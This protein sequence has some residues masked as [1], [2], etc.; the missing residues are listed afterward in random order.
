M[1]PGVSVGVLEDLVGDIG[2][3]FPR[4][5]VCKEW[6]WDRCWINRTP[7]HPLSVPIMFGTPC[8]TAIHDLIGSTLVI[9]ITHGE[10]DLVLVG[11]VEY[12]VVDEVACLVE[13]IEA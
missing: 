3:C 5:L 13:E 6:R 8:A 11:L 12:T 1:Y 10:E 9:H 7:L 2:T 4:S